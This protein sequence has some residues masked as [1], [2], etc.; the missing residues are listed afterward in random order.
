MTVKI[1]FVLP[2]LRMGGA[3]KVMISLFNNIDKVFLEPSIVAFSNGSLKSKIVDQSRLTVLDHESLLSGVFKFS[4]LVRSINPDVI[5]STHSHLNALLCFLKKLNII[6]SKL[7]IRESN[8][9]S[10]QQSNGK[11]L[12]EKYF[13]TF[14]IKTF[15]HN[16]DHLICQSNEMLKDIYSFIPKYTVPATVI[17]NPIENIP[18]YI[19]KVSKKQIISIGRLDPQKNHQLLIKAFDKIKNTIPHSLVIIGDGSEYNNLR[20]II[21]KKGLED[22]VQLTGFIENVWDEYSNSSLFVLS[23]IYE[24]FP[25]VILEAMANSTPVISSNCLSGPKEIIRDS[26]NGLLFPVG[27]VEQLSKLILKLVNDNMLS[28]YLKINAYKDL[29]RYDLT[30]ISK[31]YNSIFNKI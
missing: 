4:Q 17:Y 20:K 16:A 26:Y 23:S 30:L 1:L 18:P 7:I 21:V 6:K 8:Y 13:I 11:S 29:A 19:N 3:E 28:S 10:M 5:F 24:G 22:R 12:Y 9:L 25:N 15:Y 14:M 31:Q 27:D 2:T